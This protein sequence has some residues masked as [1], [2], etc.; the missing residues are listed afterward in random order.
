MDER[1]GDCEPEGQGGRWRLERELAR[2]VRATPIIV[3]RAGTERADDDVMDLAGA[4]E[5]ERVGGGGAGGQLGSTLLKSRGGAVLNGGW[6]VVVGDPSNPHL[7]GS[8]EGYMYLNMRNPK[9]LA[10]IARRGKETRNDRV[11]VYR[12]RCYESV[13][14]SSTGQVGIGE[15]A[16]VS[17]PWD[18]RPH[19]YNDEVTDTAIRRRWTTGTSPCEAKAAAKEDG[20]EAGRQ[21]MEERSSGRR[22][23]GSTCWGVR[24]SAS[25]ARGTES[26]SLG[27]GRW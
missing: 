12:L 14:C 18:L 11:R 16:E 17:P 9:S 26:V 23:G 7:V 2:W 15:R 22:P 8:H 3:D 25:S 1:T 24:P 27:G 6:T 10:Y 13:G 20:D 5:D 21:P 19:A 4:V